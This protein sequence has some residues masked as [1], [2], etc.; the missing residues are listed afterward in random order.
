VAER[1]QFYLDEH[2]PRAVTEGL[3]RRG[4]DVL[5]AREAGMLQA[6]DEQHLAFALSEGR[7]IVTQDAD[8]LRLH[9]AGRPH[10]GIVYVP[11]QTAVGTIVRGLMLIYDILSP[12]AM[13]N[14]VEFL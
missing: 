12:E 7:V 3:R 4:V 9:T 11:Q 5:T 6:K 13:T 2:V 14:H 8:F 10:A 1:I